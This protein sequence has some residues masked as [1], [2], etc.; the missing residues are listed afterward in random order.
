M[1]RK[2]TVLFPG[3]FT[4]RFS[5][6]IISAFLISITVEG[7][8]NES[9]I[10]FR[11]GEKISY[12]I[13]FGRFRD[14]GHAELG[15]VSQGTLAGQPA[16]EIRG[17]VRTFGFVG[18]AIAPADQERMTIVSPST[19]FPLFVKKISD[20]DGLR[21]EANTDFTKS[22]GGQFDILSLVYYIRRAGGSGSAVV[23]E[24]G[25]IYAV[26][27]R[28]TKPVTLQLAAGKFE[29]DE[30]QIDGDFL[31]VFGMR[32]LSIFLTR[33]SERIPVSIRFVNEKGEF[34]L[35]S[36]AISQTAEETP[37]P[38][39][40]PTPAPKQSPRPL[41]T[42]EPYIPNRPLSDDLPFVL[43]EAL[44]YRVTAA[45]RLV[46]SVFFRIRERNLADGRDALVL[47]ATVTDAAAGN[48]VFSLNDSVTD[49]VDPKTFVPFR[50]DL[51]FAGGLR[52]FSGRTVFDEKGFAVIGG[53]ARVAVPAGIHTLL[54]FFYA[55]RSFN[56]SPGRVPDSKVNDTRVAVFWNNVP[57]VF[58]LRPAK[59]EIIEISGK[60][61]YS[62]PV[63]ITTGDAEIDRLGLKI[64]L[65]TDLSRIPLRITLGIYK[66][67]FLA[68][69]IV[70]SQ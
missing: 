27:F 28:P 37:T 57:L 54:S 40:I 26:N 61:F 65:S 59:K 34:R 15:I 39:P 14:V 52:S 53:S 33:D 2:V 12:E 17:R 24:A 6:A 69:S 66:A 42:P 46:G 16:I 60:R 4:M 29:T 3:S 70:L 58:T 1:P 49:L 19:G 20:P 25:N 21:K 43:G 7:Q 44:E 64:W 67:E 62:Q 36:V 48:P 18:A 23:S 50:S 31:S 9:A 68:G 22:G 10:G 45:D 51:K 11:V 56:L 47:N 55:M 32:R 13:S 63:S 41:P 5:V 30:I 8:R 38:T 35:D